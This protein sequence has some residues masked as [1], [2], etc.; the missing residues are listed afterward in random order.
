MPRRDA[1]SRENAALLDDLAAALGLVEGGPRDPFAGAAPLTDPAAR[2]VYARDGS[3]IG[4]GRPVAIAIPHTAEQVAAVV[5][6]CARHGVPFVARGGGTGLSGGA[7][8]R[9]GAVVLATSR[10]NAIAPCDAAGRSVQTGPGAINEAVSRACAPHGL[11]FAPDPGS[12]G[13]ATIGGNVAE[14]AGGP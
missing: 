6:T 14:N 1:P 7:L 11:L 12:Q 13:A 8:P 4:H 2:A 10:L 3:H 9:E 5:R